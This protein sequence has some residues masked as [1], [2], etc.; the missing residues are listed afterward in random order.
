[1]MTTGVARESDLRQI[2]NDRRRDAADEGGAR[3]G[4][5]EAMLSRVK[6]ET[7]SRIDIALARLDEGSY[8][9]CAECAG[10]IAGRRLRALPF[11]MRCQDC[12][13]RREQC[14][15]ERDAEARQRER[16]HHDLP[17]FSDLA[18]S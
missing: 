10:E 18:Q 14:E 3:E 6:A 1:M 5:A 4:A 7:R 12:E 16:R 2:L 15:Q 8:G 13:D 11:A 17:L 9:T